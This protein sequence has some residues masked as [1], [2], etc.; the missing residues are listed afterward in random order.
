MARTRE[1]LRQATRRR[2]VD[3]AARLFQERGF[4][5]ATIRDIAEAAGVS[6]GT[7]MAV[8]DKKGL[9]V[10]VFDGLIAEGH[11]ERSAGSGS[12]AEGGCVDR[13][14]GL[15]RPFV[16]MFTARLDLSRAYASVLVTGEHTSTLFT[17]LAERLV[18]E[19]RAAI[20]RHGCIPDA[21]A[22]A[23]ARALYFAYI[24][25]LFAWSGRTAADT[26]ELDT[27]LRDAFA[28]ICDCREPR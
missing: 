11:R 1:E 2:V 7:V 17:S 24:G 5:A 9:L 16:G 15:V 13:L 18:E 21:D 19:M 6:V 26:A 28:A 23:K 12:G 25:V 8:G 10:L 22:A 4:A 3:A 27:G 14:M 20:T